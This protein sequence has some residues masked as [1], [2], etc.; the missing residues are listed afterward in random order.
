MRRHLM[1]Q[2]LI[3]FCT[4]FCIEKGYFNSTDVFRMKAVNQ[5]LFIQMSHQ[6]NVHQVQKA[7]RVVNIVRSLANS[8]TSGVEAVSGS[9][10]AHSFVR[11]L[12]TI[13]GGIEGKSFFDAGCG[14]GI[15]TLIAAYL[16]AS[17]S[18]GLDTVV[19]LPVLSSI[20]MA[21]RSRLGISPNTANIGF[22]DLSDMTC[23]PHRPHMVFTFWEGIDPVARDNIV[24][25]TS[26]S[27]TVTVFACS[28][29]P[30]ETPELVC[31]ALNETCS[32][33]QTWTLADNFQVSATGGMQRR[34][35]IFKRNVKAVLRKAESLDFPSDIAVSFYKLASDQSCPVQLR[36]REGSSGLSM[37]DLLMAGQALLKE[38]FSNFQALSSGGFGRVIRVKHSTCPDRQCVLKIGMEVFSD[39]D[40]KN[41]SILREFAAMLQLEPDLGVSANLLH[42]FGG[43]SAL[44]KINLG[45]GRNVSVLCMQSCWGDCSSLRIK[46]RAEFLS[47]GAQALSLNCCL[48]F[49]KILHLLS[50]L[51][52]K[53]I[54]H[55]DMKWANILLV[56]EWLPDKDIN[57]VLGDFGI[58][59]LMGT[60][61][62]TAPPAPI[63]TPKTQ[64][65]SR[66]AEK[67]LKKALEK[68]AVEA[69]GSLSKAANT[70]PLLTAV[71]EAML[72]KEMI[73]DQ[74]L[75]LS[76]GTPGYRNDVMVNLSYQIGKK[77]T[78]KN[79]IKHQV[80]FVDVCKH[81][82]RSVATMLCEVMRGKSDGVWAK[83]R[84]CHHRQYEL[85]LDKLRTQ[86]EVSDFL[87]KEKSVPLDEASQQTQL[88]CKLVK[89]M[90]R[91]DSK[92]LTAKEAANHDFFTL[93]LRH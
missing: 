92:Q 70:F 88:L 60:Q 35:W 20:F 18:T 68:Q 33:G 87:L 65:G 90:L 75:L 48:F 10:T 53:G 28:N 54:G 59:C 77:P 4:E 64:A 21:A 32:E 31:S 67:C 23:F 19:N 57:V 13:E 11:V 89:D 14:C 27:P 16:G 61:Y 45:E 5:A 73:S 7:S 47:D 22:G 71:T 78:K 3:L 15:P 29:A 39:E 74:L 51:H 24:K 30:G 66:R 49:Q 62:V 40:F 76:T 91:S 85:E 69:R 37:K 86:Q 42:L 79:N 93:A 52:E 8:A 12:D 58:S 44:A 2:D 26:E 25:M 84:R 17:S 36:K 72:N 63:P 41:D 80:D 50:V 81:D 34:V 9:F 56:N 43:I 1:R 6:F 38:G 46:F 55:N 82:V 83:G